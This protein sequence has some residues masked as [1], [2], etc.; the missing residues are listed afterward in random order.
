MKEQNS[1]RKVETNRNDNREEG[2]YEEG[3]EKEKREED[4]EEGEFQ[5]IP[6]QENVS[7]ASTEEDK[8]DN[9][10]EDNNKI[11]LHVADNIGTMD[12]AIEDAEPLNQQSLEEETDLDF[13]VSIWV[14]Q[15]IIKLSKEFGVDFSGCEREAME[16]FM[17]IDSRRQS[18][19]G[20]TATQSYQTPKRK[21]VKELKALELGSNFKS[22]GTRSRGGSI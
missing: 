20:K 17:K 19:R 8:E 9:I 15:N 14:R 13:E 7:A 2:K 6:M 22:N 5:I 18:S 16:L 21:G 12:W 4:N 10:S 11:I 3:E 1:S